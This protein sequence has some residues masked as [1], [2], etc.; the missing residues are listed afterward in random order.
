MKHGEVVLEVALV[1]K[2]ISEI[3][4]PGLTWFP[5]QAGNCNLS[6]IF[7]FRAMLL[8]VRSA[9]VIKFSGA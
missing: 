6:A 2:D 4:K 5:R 3:I 9:E 1:K 7:S 8:Q